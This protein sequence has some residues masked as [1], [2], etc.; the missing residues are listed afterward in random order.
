M[1]SFKLL[2]IKLSHEFE[3]NVPDLFKNQYPVFNEMKI[4]DILN[5]KELSMQYYKKNYD[6]INKNIFYQR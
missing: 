3:K 4:K 2:V 1:H 5:D 6:K